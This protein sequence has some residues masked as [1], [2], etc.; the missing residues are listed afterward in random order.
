MAVIWP[1]RVCSAVWSE[2]F[3]AVLPQAVSDN[4][5]AAAQRME[6]VFLPFIKMTSFVIVCCLVLVHG[7]GA[8]S[9]PPVN[10]VIIARQPKGDLKKRRKIVLA[11]KNLKFD[12]DI[13]PHFNVILLSIRRRRRALSARGLNP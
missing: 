7:A 1:V 2:L 3:A 5:R 13:K 12:I 8:L 4:A 9:G 10:A 11:A 6:Q